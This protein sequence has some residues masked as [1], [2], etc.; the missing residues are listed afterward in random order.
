MKR[1]VSI[2]HALI[3]TITPLLVVSIAL[4]LLIVQSSTQKSLYEVA[5]D[6]MSRN[7]DWT[8]R[9]LK[10]MVTPAQEIGSYVTRQ[11]ALGEDD[12]ALAEVM[13]ERLKY[14]SHLYSMYIGRPDGSF[15]LAGWRPYHMQNDQPLWLFIKKITVEDGQR[16]VEIVWINPQDMDDREVLETPED[17]YDP[18]VRPWY[19]DVMSA[20]Q[21]AWTSPYVFYMTG[22]AGITYAIPIHDDNEQLES[23]V[24][25]DLQLETLA[26]FLNKNR[27]S[28]N[29]V[30]FIFTENGKILSHPFLIDHLRKHEIPTLETID[31]AV[32]TTGF[33]NYKASGFSA[34][35]QAY[36]TVVDDGEEK[37]DVVFR[38]TSMDSGDRLVIGEHVPESDYLVS[39]RTIQRNALL[40]SMALMLA[41]LIVGVILAKRMARPIKTLKTMANRVADF[42]FS[43]EIH[44]LSSMEEIHETILSFNKMIKNLE[45]QR[46]KNKDLMEHLRQI[47]DAMP[48]LLL[49][50]DADGQIGQWNRFAVEKTGISEADAVGHNVFTVLPCLT[51]FRDELLNKIT[52]NQGFQTKC[53]LAGSDE[54]R[55]LIVSAYPLILADSNEMVIRIDDET[56][57]IRIEE[58]MLQTEKMLSIGGLAAGMAHEINNPLSIISQAAQNVSRRLSPEVK[59][60][61]D[62]AEA[63]GL[64]LDLVER[65]L[66]QRGINGFLNNVMEG[67]DRSSEILRNMLS[68]NSDNTSDRELCSIT[69]IVKD[70]IQLICNNYD[71]KKKQDFRNIEIDLDLPDDLPDVEVN[72]VEIQQ[73]VLNLLKNAGQAVFELED[74]DREPLIK[75]FARSENNQLILEISDNGMG[76]P[77]NIQPRIFE[78]FFTT[79][80]VGV[81]TGLGLAVSYFIITKRHEGSLQLESVEG[82]GATFRIILPLN[83]QT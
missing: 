9:Y 8:E 5:S 82:Q 75:V 65:Y 66:D 56:E 6:T 26:A 25:I 47:V 33:K 31:D 3:M 38:T 77:E 60:N 27:F 39:I 10:T 1:R 12:W 32:L 23:V 62:I 70:S 48:S 2:T 46:Q 43:S 19:K 29:S 37:R 76:I 67:V 4:I 18:R 72:P 15:I 63:M 79:K 21:S 51:E 17:A 55:N 80:E 13:L 36:L 53:A 78:P 71:L 35:M 28:E 54:Q 16:T 73:V 20:G 42:D 45:S 74:G 69:D 64:D 11:V 40:V 14:S 59:A 30:N 83:A 81:G 57:R 52:E 61:R 44:H 68:F 58:M 34:E 49:T 50:V 24:G 7:A 41:S 22:K